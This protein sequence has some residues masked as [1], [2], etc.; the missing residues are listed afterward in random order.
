MPTPS[1][2]EVA[3]RYIAGASADLWCSKFE[4]SLL[5]TRLLTHAY[6]VIGH[7][8]VGEI[9]TTMIVKVLEPIWTSKPTAA[10]HLRWHIEKISILRR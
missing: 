2:C 3:E 7:V 10:P 1:F 4:K 8:P 6:L 5:H 9:D